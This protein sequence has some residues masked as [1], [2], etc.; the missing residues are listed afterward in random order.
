MRDYEHLYSGTRNNG[1]VLP[2]LNWKGQEKEG[3]QARC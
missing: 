3:L 1:I 2:P